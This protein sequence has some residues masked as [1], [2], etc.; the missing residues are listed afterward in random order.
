MF[1][2]AQRLLVATLVTLGTACDV[3]EPP[4]PTADE[5]NRGLIVLYP[6]ALNTRSEMLGF[7]SG[8]RAAGIDQAIEVRPWAPPLLNF[9]I[10]TE[11][12]EYERPW[13]REE[14]ARLAAHRAA[15]PGS[16]V[17]LLGFSGGAMV[18][19]LVGEEMPAGEQ[20]DRIILMSPGIST[21]YDLTRMLENTTDGAYVYWSAKDTVINF[22]T[23]WLGT[24]DGV[25]G[26]AAAAFGFEMEHPKLRQVS[27]SPAL[28]LFGNNGEHNDYA[29][30][31]EWIR[32]FVAPWVAHFDAAKADDTT[33]PA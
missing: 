8:L 23:H 4:A 31:V 27:W 2:L 3:W 29:F 14:A 12:L 11:F 15:N 1:R 33:P 26:P 7:Y 21:A 17:T 16:P 5:L 6:G 22:T 18:C 25:F 24:L 32:E 9:F 20:I 28:A 10:P 30:S 19:V 13:A